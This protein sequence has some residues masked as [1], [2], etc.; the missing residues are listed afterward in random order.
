MVDYISVLHA[1]LI[2]GVFSFALWKENPYF[3]FCEHASLGTGLGFTFVQIVKFISTNAVSPLIKSNEII[4][5]VPIILG[6]MLYTRFKASTR[7]ISRYPMMIVIGVGMA[8]GMRGGLFTYI[9]SQIKATMNMSIMTN[10]AL[11][12]FNN[13]VMLL[14]TVFVLLFFTFTILKGETKGSVM[15]RVRRISRIFIMAG[16]GGFFGSITLARLTLIAGQI[17]KLLL[18]FGL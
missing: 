5:L 18:A 2:M 14:I 13:L 8:L 12:N 4:Y 10:N 9:I 11:T 1:V 15:Y 3:R 16:L 17:K 6:L 7:W